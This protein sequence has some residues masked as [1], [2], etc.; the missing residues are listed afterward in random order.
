MDK[1]AGETVIGEDINLSEVQI[2]PF[3]SYIFLNVHIILLYRHE[4]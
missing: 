3:A 2:K 4:E 1:T